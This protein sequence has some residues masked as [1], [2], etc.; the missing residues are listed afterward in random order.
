[1]SSDSSCLVSGVEN[2]LHLGTHASVESVK[3]KAEVPPVFVV[4]RQVMAEGERISLVQVATAVLQALGDWS[5]L[6]AV[7]PMRQGWSYTC[8]P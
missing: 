1:M 7:Q 6:D 4:Y 3:H 5:S 8:I 2:S